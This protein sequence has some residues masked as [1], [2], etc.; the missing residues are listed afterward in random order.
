MD[1]VQTWRPEP[2][3]EFH[4][5]VIGFDMFGVVAKQGLADESVD[6]RERAQR[7]GGQ[8]LV[9]HQQQPIGPAQSLRDGELDQRTA[10]APFRPLVEALIGSSGGNGS[11][12][13]K[14]C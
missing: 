4:R 9:A 2:G 7:V 5:G 11:S 13:L 6:R 12:R 3:V 1:L 8:G 10:A 14:R